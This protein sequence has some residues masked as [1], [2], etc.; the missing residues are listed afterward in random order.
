MDDVTR[1]QGELRTHGQD[2]LLRFWGELTEPQRQQLA[3]EIASV[4][5][6]QIGQLFQSLTVTAEQGRLG[7]L[8]PPHAVRLGDESPQQRRTAQSLGEEAIAA[9]KVGMILV[10]GGQGTRLGF[11]RPKGLFPLGP[12]SGRTLFE[13]IVDQLRAVRRRTGAAIPLWI[14]TSPATDDETREYFRQHDHLGLP[15]D[16]VFFFC[17]G[18]MPAVDCDTGKVLLAQPHRLALSPNGHGGMLAALAASGGLEQ[19]RQRGVEY[20]FYGQVDNPL[21][22][23]CDAR[24]IGYHIEQRSELTSLAVAKRSGDERVGNFVSEAGRIRI[25]EYSDFP[26]ELA[27]QQN[28]AGELRFWAG[29]IAVHVFG[30][31]FLRRCSQQPDSL[32]YHRALK[33]TPFVDSDGNRVEPQHPNSLKFERFIFDLLPLAENGLV[34]EVDRTETFAPVK[35]APGAATDTAATAQAAMV[36]RFRSWLQAAGAVVGAGAIEIHPLWAAN[37]EETAQRLA[38]GTPIDGDTYFHPEWRSGN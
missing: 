28:R 7:N 24:M 19:A 23:V 25:I 3:D 11:P 1:L 37:A 9:G 12:L 10:A 31:D 15:T 16:D 35:N 30:A 14:L 6:P 21:L 17:Q 27:A 18:T 5:F 38:S 33:K 2:H 26:Q 22:P 4:D 32:P 29:S 20:F 34:V 8:A 13:I 36:A